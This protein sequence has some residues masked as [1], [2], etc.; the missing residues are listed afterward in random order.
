MKIKIKA[1]NENH[2]VDFKIVPD[3]G[4]TH[5]S[6]IAS[7]SKELD[8]LQTAISDR[9][10]NDDIIGVIIAKAISNKLKL[11]V[12]FDYDY[13]GSGYG[14]KFDIYSIVKKLK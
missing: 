4:K 12:E 7:S 2:I 10:A 1:G 9:D 3:I 13:N 14:L 8:L 5:M 6:A 11:P